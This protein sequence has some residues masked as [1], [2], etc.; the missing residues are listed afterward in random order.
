M[1]HKKIRVAV[2]YG[3]RS[4]EHEVSLRSAASVIQKLDSSRYEI[5][6]VAID[7][8]GRWHLNDLSL[9]NKAADVLPVLK[10]AP[11]V[12]L[13]PNPQANGSSLIRLGGGGDDKGVD[14]VF[15]VMHGTYCEDGTIQGL[16]E[17]ADVPYVGCGVLASAVGMD[18][19]VAKRLVRDAG[20][21]I[22]PYVMLRADRWK[23][24]KALFAS[25]IA[26]D[27]G[28]PCFVKP[29]NAGSSVGVHK[30]KS[31]ADLE[32]ALTDSFRYDTKV[33]VERAVQAREIELSVL[34]NS[35]PGGD[36]LVSVPG[37]VTPTHEFYSYEAKYLDENGAALMIPAKL[38]PEQ[39]KA[40]QKI[41]RDAFVALECEGMAR[42]DLFL[43]KV[44][45]AFY[46]N[47][48]NT[49]PGFTSISMYPKMWE[50]SGIAYTEL[51]SRLIDLA[52]ARHARKKSLVRD[53][54]AE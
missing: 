9:I 13:P 39:I 41:A 15:P 18:K 45:G 2:L 47:E 50:A 46:F 25:K 54:H 48:V 34:E 37:E 24:E 22:V 29:V 11:V 23:R 6:P 21:P 36:P 28:F 53:F 19:E 20:I 10:D 52:I 43:D 51:L 3:G 16:L 33:L 32:A 38:A 1:T 17:L 27:L 49:L 35:D 12:V 30:V 40:A 5:V 44:S 42:V 7:K 26:T 14:V 8:Q 4:G 31:A